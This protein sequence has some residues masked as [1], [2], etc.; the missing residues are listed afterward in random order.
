V[1][2]SLRGDLIAICTF[3]KKGSRGEALVSLVT[4]DRTRGKGMQQHQGAFR[5]DMRKGS[6]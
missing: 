2:L 4:S 5:W 6:S 1:A 3:C